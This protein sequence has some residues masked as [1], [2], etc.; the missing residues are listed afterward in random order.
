M[1]RRNAA[2]QRLLVLVQ[3]ALENQLVLVDILTNNVNFHCH[4]AFLANFIQQRVHVG[5]L[6]AVQV[7]QVL[8][9][10][11]ERF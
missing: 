3:E 10:R 1:A 8:C 11:R 5:R 9:T 4:F 7:R 2:A 6:I